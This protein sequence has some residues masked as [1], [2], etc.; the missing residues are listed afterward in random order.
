MNNFTKPTLLLNANFYPLSYFPLSLINWQSALKSAFLGRVD[1]VCEYDTV[2]RSQSMTMKIPSVI[3]LKKYL[4]IKTCPTFNRFNV[5]L[6]DD[7]TCQYCLLKLPTTNLTFDHVIPKYRNGKTN[8]KNVVTA[9]T[10]CNFKK[11]HKQL[12]EVDL[13]LHKFPKEP[14]S[15]DLQ[16]IGRKYPP[17]HLHQS[18][19]DFLYWDCNLENN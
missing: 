11:G 8:W 10:S 16:R 13:T 5:F 3:S 7:F 15:K 2:I 19:M 4:K 6:R 14:T 1:V 18:W 12:H 17:K 9:C